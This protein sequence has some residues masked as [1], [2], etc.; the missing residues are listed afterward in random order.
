MPRRVVTEAQLALRRAQFAL[1]EAQLVAA[2]EAACEAAAG[3][4]CRGGLPPADRGAWDRET[5]RRYLAARALDAELGP[6]MRRLH[7]EIEQLERDNAAAPAAATLP[8]AA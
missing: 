8:D 3:R 7:A 4:G 6:R 2:C 1:L 5:W